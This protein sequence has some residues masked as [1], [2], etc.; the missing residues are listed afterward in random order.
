MHTLSDEKCRSEVLVAFASQL[1]SY[2]LQTGLAI[3]LEISDE[4]YRADALT[5]FK[6]HLTDVDSY[7][8]A[9]RQAVADH[10]RTS[11]AKKER[12]EMLRFCA[13]STFFAPPI[14]SP[15]TLAAIAGHIIEICQEWE[16]L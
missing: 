13:D 5:A 11:L 8:R 3:T 15:T 14:L 10:L 12:K 1:I 16:W 4:K 7:L 9:T 2:S 6:S